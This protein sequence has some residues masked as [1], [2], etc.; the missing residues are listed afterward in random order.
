MITWIIYE[1]DRK[2]INFYLPN[3]LATKIY[4]EITKK[5]QGDFYLNNTVRLE[6]FDKP[7]LELTLA[8]RNK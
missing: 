7:F 5:K 2:I 3:N 8:N 1:E 4:K 6:D